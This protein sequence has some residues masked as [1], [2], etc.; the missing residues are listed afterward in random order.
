MKLAILGYGT[1]GAGV[2]ELALR[3][4]FP[5]RHVLDLRP[6]PEGTAATID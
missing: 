1:I 3:S 5:V 2:Y 6:V 4:G